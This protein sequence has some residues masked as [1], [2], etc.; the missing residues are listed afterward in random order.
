[1]EEIR[2]LSLIVPTYKQERTIV[3]N[4]KSLSKV[5][6][7]LPYSY[8][9]IVVIDGKV[10]QSFKKIKKIK[11]P[12]V[13][14]FEYEKNKGKGYAVRFGMSKAEGD[15][16]G[17]ID[18]GMDIDPAGILMLL[19]HM[20]WYN[21][22]I[23]MGSKLHPVSY[24]NYPFY[25]KILSWGYRTFTHLMFGFNVRDTQVGLKFF[26]KK[27][28][29]DVF[30]RLLVKRFAFDVEIL[31]VAYYLGYRR[32]FEAPIKLDFNGKSTIKP[33][34]FLKI[35]SKMLWDTV[36]VFYRLRILNYYD[37]KNKSHWIKQ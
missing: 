12:S 4:I 24:V 18:A 2:L 10:D 3:N 23:I 34:N 25:R 14:V 1:M 9:I 16:I 20:E 35:I 21:A 27:V 15:V 32:I 5:L 37:I 11:N 22:D 28:V 26:K 6:S 29:K 36:T 13:K 8:E 31:A 33:T 7:T 17:F 30:P 19:N